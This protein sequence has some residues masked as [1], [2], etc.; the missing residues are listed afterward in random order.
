MVMNETILLLVVIHIVCVC[1]YVIAHIAHMPMYTHTHSHTLI[2]TFTHTHTQYAYAC[3]AI[4]SP[5]STSTPH[6]THK[7]THLGHV[8]L[9]QLVVDG[10]EVILYVGTFSH[11]VYKFKLIHLHFSCT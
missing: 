6:P 8:F 1:K 5:L 7:H 3:T 11:A 9:E 2:H 10:D 4:L